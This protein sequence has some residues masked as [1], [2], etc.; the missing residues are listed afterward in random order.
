VKPGWDSH[1]VSILND[2]PDIA[3]A[4]YA[5]GLLGANAVGCAAGTGENIDYVCGW[6][7]CFTRDTYERFGLFDEAHLQFAYGEDSDFSLRLKEAGYRIFASNAALVDHFGNATI[8]EV[9]KKRNT[10]AT[11][12]ANHDYLRR[13][14]ASYL[15]ERRILANVQPVER[16]MELAAA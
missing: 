15:K 8:R 1:L 6:C 2:R 13:R 9:S 11:F 12:T 16:Q 10:S 3:E 7:A 4:G 5:G 14:W